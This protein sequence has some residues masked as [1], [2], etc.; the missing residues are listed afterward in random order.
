MAHNIGG[1]WLDAKNEQVLSHR[2]HSRLLLNSTVPKFPG[3][4]V[5]AW[6][7]LRAAK[8][9]AKPVQQMLISSGTR[10]D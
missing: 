2:Q 4:C 10:L 9:E 8:S 3:C 5:A 6:P 1:Q 7:C